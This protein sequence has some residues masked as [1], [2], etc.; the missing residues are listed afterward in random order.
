VEVEFEFPTTIITVDRGGLLP[1]FP[2]DFI[3]LKVPLIVVYVPQD[4][5]RMQGVDIKG[6]GAEMEKFAAS[7]AGVKNRGLLHLHPR[8]PVTG[9][10]S[11]LY[12]LSGK[13][14]DI[15]YYFV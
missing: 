15:S 10:Q 14:Q 8:S 9:V 7:S 11:L 13:I 6:A 12:I 4:I 1:A 5:I 3:V 2:T